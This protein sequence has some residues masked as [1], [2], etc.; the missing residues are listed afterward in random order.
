V[1]GPVDVLAVIRKHAETH[2]ALAGSDAYSEQ[3]A[4]KLEATHAAVADL[5]EAHKALYKHYVNTLESGR[6]RIISLGGD[7]DPVDRMERSDPVLMHSRA[8]LANVGSAS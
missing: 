3:E 7:C 6:D 1:N 4:P 5:I 2:R 8:I